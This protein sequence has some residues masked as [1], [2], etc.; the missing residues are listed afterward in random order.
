MD[1]LTQILTP[2]RPT[3]IVDVGANPIDGDPPYKRMLAA[4]LCDV[5]GF[6][7]QDEAFARLVAK[8]GPRERYLPYALGDG[9]SGTLNVCSLEGMT[10]LKVP[11][12][13]H[14]AL[15]NL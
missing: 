3:A 5:V 1:L 2:Q 12:P 7:P 15:F 13:E 14:L 10:S 9:T 6:E 4:G 11:A 8:A